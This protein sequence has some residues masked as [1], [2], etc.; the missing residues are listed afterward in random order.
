MHRVEN[1]S[2]RCAAAVAMSVAVLRTEHW[3]WGSAGLI[4]SGYFAVVSALTLL[5]PGAGMLRLDRDGF[6]TAYLFRRRR[7]RWQVVGGFRAMSIRMSTMAV[8]DDTNPSGWVMAKLNMAVCG[9]NAGL[10]DT[11]GLAARDLA[12]LMTRWRERAMLPSSP[13]ERPLLEPRVTQ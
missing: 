8:Y 7:S 4:F 11:Y 9:R 2:W 5:L 1:G 3:G 12:G 6:E 13:S 10:P